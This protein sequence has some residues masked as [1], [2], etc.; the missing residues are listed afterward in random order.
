MVGNLFDVLRTTLGDYACIETSKYLTLGENIL[1][2]SAWVIVVGIGCIIFLNFIIA[3]ASASY[4]KVYDRLGEFIEK[5][6]SNLIAE[7]EDMTPNVFKS[8]HNFPKYIIIRQV[9]S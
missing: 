8:M 9:D 1:F 3:E 4:E 7:S 6:K 2:W 5:E